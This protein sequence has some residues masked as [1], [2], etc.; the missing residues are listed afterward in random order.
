MTPVPRG[1]ARSEPFDH[2]GLPQVLYRL[3]RA[4]YLAR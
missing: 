3:T 2:A 4:A 1:P